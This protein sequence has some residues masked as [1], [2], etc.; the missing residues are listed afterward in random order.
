MEHC[1]YPSTDV[2]CR[3]EHLEVEP[4]DGSTVIEPAS[5]SLAPLTLRLENAAETSPNPRPIERLLSADPHPVDTP[6]YS[7]KAVLE[8]SPRALG[9]PKPIRYRATSDGPPLAGE[10]SATQNPTKSD[11]QDWGAIMKKAQKELGEAWEALSPEQRDSMRADEQKW[12]A[13][14]NGEP[15]QIRLQSI[16]NRAAW[17]WHLAGNKERDRH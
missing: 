7:G 10:Q 5:F 9:D 13:Q 4:G 3:E 15:F 11:A 17:L 8:E 14:N 1:S 12:E 16:T 6:R 2:P